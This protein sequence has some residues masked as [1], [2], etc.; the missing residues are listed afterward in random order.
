MTCNWVGRAGI[1]LVVLLSAV[2]GLRAQQISESPGDC[3]AQGAQYARCALWLD[4]LTLRRGADGEAMSKGG[5]FGPMKLE[6]HLEGDSA[7]SYARAYYR[8]AKR[9][10]FLNWGAVVFEL[11]GLIVA[12]SYRCDPDPV[13]H[14]CTRTDDSYTMGSFALLFGGMTMQLASLPFANRARS[15]AAKA[16]L[17]HN[18]K[19]AR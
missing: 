18:A 7:R 14:Y 15:Q 8:N 10:N 11:A 12:R 2:T 13:F 1:G 6:M 17:W 19:F 3:S 9:A 16:V 5:L 4:G